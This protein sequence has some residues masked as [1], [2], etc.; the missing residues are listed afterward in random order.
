MIEPINTIKEPVV[1]FGKHEVSGGVHCSSR[2]CSVSGKFCII[3][4][5]DR[6]ER[7]YHSIFM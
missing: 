1:T 2:H 5:D 6:L 7:L 4:D 3:T